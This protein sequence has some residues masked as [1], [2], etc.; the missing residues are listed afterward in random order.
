MNLNSEKRSTL[1]AATSDLCWLF[2]RGYSTPS[3]LK[4]VGDRYALTKRQRTA[5]AR[6]ACSIE[7]VKRRRRHR[8]QPHQLSGHE[9]WLDGYNVLTPSKLRCPTE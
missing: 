5:V 8:L 9:V 1:R 3:A 7:A 6:C 4:L 2:D